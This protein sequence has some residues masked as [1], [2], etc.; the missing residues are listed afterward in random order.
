MTSSKEV[1]AAFLSIGIVSEC[2][3]DMPK[4]RGRK[5]R[6]QKNHNQHKTQ[7]YGVRKR[8]KLSIKL[9]GRLERKMRVRSIIWGGKNRHNNMCESHKMN[10]KKILWSFNKILL[11]IIFF[12]RGKVFSYNVGIR[13]KDYFN[14]H[15]DNVPEKKVAKIIL[16]S[17]DGSVEKKLLKLKLLVI[18]C[19]FCSKIT[20]KLL[21]KSQVGGEKVLFTTFFSIHLVLS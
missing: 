2:I 11:L 15:F 21:K 1:H 8:R 14:E 5:I 18:N 9:Y 13:R 16:H 17:M 19:L 20:Q 6:K 7:K 10:F 4:R 3:W 12:S